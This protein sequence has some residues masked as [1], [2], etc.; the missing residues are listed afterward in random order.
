MAVSHSAT[1]VTECLSL[2]VFEGVGG[3][4]AEFSHRVLKELLTLWLMH[5]NAFCCY[6]LEKFKDENCF[7]LFGASFLSKMLLNIIL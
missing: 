6:L 4:G 1:A 2:P 7:I 3:Q 5:K